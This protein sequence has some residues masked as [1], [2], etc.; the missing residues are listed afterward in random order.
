[1][2]LSKQSAL[3]NQWWHCCFSWKFVNFFYSSC[4]I[5]C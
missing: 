3:N 4:S 2:F 1:M 5:L